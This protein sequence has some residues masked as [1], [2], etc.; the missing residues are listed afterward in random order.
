LPA[1]DSSNA[2]IKM[3]SLFS[4]TEFKISGIQLGHTKEHIPFLN[5]TVVETQLYTSLFY[6][7]NKHRIIMEEVFCA[8]A[9]GNKGSEQTSL[10][11]CTLVHH[12]RAQC[13]PAQII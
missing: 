8:E 9:T 13:S 5:T 2:E 12:D 3:A 4:E 11:T 10:Y 7:L 1:E 6:S